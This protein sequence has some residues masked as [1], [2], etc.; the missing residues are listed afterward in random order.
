MAMDKERID[1]ILLTELTPD[2]FVSVKPHDGGDAQRASRSFTARKARRRAIKPLP[3]DLP[4]E[5]EK[6]TQRKRTVSR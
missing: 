6:A 2:E 4:A 1:E 5:R 3:A